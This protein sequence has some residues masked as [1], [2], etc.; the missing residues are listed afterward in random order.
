MKG[1]LNPVFEF[2]MEPELIEVDCYGVAFGI[3]CHFSIPLYLIEMTE[4]FASSE[5]NEKNLT[6]ITVR[7]HTICLKCG[8]FQNRTLGKQ[9]FTSH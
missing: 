2:N 8:Q 5:N 1:Q 6:V 9:T 3:L 7:N 4:G